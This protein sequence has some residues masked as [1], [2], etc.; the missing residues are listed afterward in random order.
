MLTLRYFMLRIRHL[1]WYFVI[2]ADTLS[3]MLIVF[4]DMLIFYFFKNA[5]SWSL[6][7]NTSSFMLILCHL[8][9]YF[10]IICWYFIKIC[11]FLV[12]RCFIYFVIYVNTES[13]YANTNT[14]LSF[15]L[16]L[17][18]V[19]WFLVSYV[20]TSWY[21]DTSSLYS[22]TSSLNAD[23]SSFMIIQVL[24]HYILSL[25]HNMLSYWCFLDGTLT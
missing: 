5:G 9:W 6:Y 3:F 21:A 24:H 15:M 2:Y 23:I 16:I 7:T 12:S 1:C 25:D 14:S 11:R 19:C 20:D 22:G 18:N 13:L 10:S 4:Y 17:L 8:S